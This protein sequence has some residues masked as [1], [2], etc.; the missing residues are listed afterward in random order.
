MIFQDFAVLAFAIFGLLAFDLYANRTAS[1]PSLGNATK[2]SVFYIF[3]ALC[4]SGYIWVAH[5][6]AES[7]LFLTGYALEKVL[8][9]DNLFA[10]MIIFE[11]FGIAAIFQRRI[12]YWGILGAIIFRAIFVVLG[13]SFAAGFGPY[14]EIAFAA[15]IGWTAYKMLFNDG[16][17]DED[18]SI[19]YKNEWYVKILGR[20][21]PITDD[22]SSGKMTVMKPVLTGS[23]GTV[24]DSAGGK[25]MR[26]YATPFLVCLVAIEIADVIFSFDS[27]PA[28][29]AVTK[30][31]YLVFSAMM[32]AILGLRSLYFVLEALKT[33]LTRLETAVIVILMFIAAKLG[34]Q[35]GS[36]IATTYG[37]FGIKE[38]VHIDPLW[39]LGIIL[40]LLI[41]GMVWS[42]I[43][44][45]EDQEPA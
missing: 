19:D 21:L 23:G 29:I 1:V 35:A 2:W 4:F 16:D 43:D 8:A 33:A 12:L 15:I 17:G 30:E 5:S 39:S 9:V 13:T 18:T 24:A 37:W 31:P 27:V 41:G 40:A 34:I 22:V 6:P 44:P 14:A 28:V 26:R 38:P 36:E 11:Y 10:F 32:F 3:A 20:F 42:K 7:Q 25:L 45:K